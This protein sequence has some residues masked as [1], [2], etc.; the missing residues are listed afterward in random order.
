MTC[1]LKAYTFIPCIPNVKITKLRT[2]KTIFI[3]LFSIVLLFPCNGQVEHSAWDFPIKPG[4]EKWKSLKSHLEK[5]N[6]C[7]IPSEILPN[8]STPELVKICLDYPL[9]FTVTFFNNMQQG[10]EQNR[11]EFNGFEELFKRIDAG[12][13]LINL[14]SEINPGDVE[15]ISTDLDKG[16]FKFRIFYLE[17]LLSQDDLIKSLNMEKQKIL[18][19]ECLTKVEEK[20][21]ASFSS[22]QILTTHLIMSRILLNNKFSNFLISY[23]ENKSK[24]DQFVYGMYPPGNGLMKE[25]QVFTRV[26]LSQQN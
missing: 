19:T 6:V 9:L 12:E 22:F 16:L 15:L 1:N 2:M 4:S 26:F 24:Y 21:K 14:Y 7:Q 3:L 17:I 20:A 23:K 13:T 10:F 11:R 18:L 25:I 8:L 5:V